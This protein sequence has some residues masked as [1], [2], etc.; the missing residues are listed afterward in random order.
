MDSSV[1]SFLRAAVAAF[2]SDRHVLATGAARLL[3]P[4]VDSNY[5]QQSVSII[6]FGET[7]HVPKRIHFSGLC[8]ANLETQAAF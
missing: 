8:E 7:V 6:V 1:H 4:F 5:R 3:S 2:P